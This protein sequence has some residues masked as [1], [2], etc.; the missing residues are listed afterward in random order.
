MPRSPQAGDHL[1]RGAARRGIEARRRLVEEDQLGVADQRERDVEPAALAAGERGRALIGLRGQADERKRLID[2]A[3]RR[4]VAGVER[5]ALAHREAR[6]GPGFLQ[7]D[8]DPR[9]PAAGRL[10]RVRAEHLDLAAA[11]L[12]KALEDLDRGR[13][14]RPVG[15]E[16]REDLPAPD[17]QVD[18]ARQPR[19]R[20]S[21]CCRPRTR[22][23]VSARRRA[24]VVCCAATAA[25]SEFVSM[26]QKLRQPSCAV[27]GARVDLGL[28]PW[29]ENQR[30]T[31]STRRADDTCLRAPYRW[32]RCCARSTGS[33]TVC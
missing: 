31:R 18:T 6:L 15:P 25:S 12:A 21:A 30:A 28:H 20:R 22:I 2:V 23:T 1:P 11:R 26:A 32:R 3:R 9:A 10:P 19:G 16:E 29:V 8:P 13:L 5:D 14:A 27:I 17:L 4:V 24:S 7:H 33:A